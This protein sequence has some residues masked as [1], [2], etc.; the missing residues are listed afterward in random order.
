MV[1][2]RPGWDEIFL[3]IVGEISKRST[4]DRG[5]VACVIVKNQRIISMGYAGSP[6]GHPHCDEVGHLII[7]MENEEGVKTNHCNRTIHSEINAIARAAREGIKLDGSILYCS[8]V[9]CSNCAKIIIQTGIQEVIC[10]YNYH[11]STLTKK[12]FDLANIKLKIIHNEY[13]KY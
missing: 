8:L 12:L 2:K 9:P 6:N 13:K 10:N 11:A 7:K 4:C 5:R 1:F 3:N